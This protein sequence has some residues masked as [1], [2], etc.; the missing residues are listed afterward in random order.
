MEGLQRGLTRTVNDLALRKGLLK[1]G[2]RLRGEFVRA[3]L[4][5]AVSGEDGSLFGDIVDAENEGGGLG[6][7]RRERWIA[8]GERG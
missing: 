8:G 4:V 5:A 3:G 6:W 2:D 1:D 7:R